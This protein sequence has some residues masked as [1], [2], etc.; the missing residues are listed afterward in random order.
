M[1]AAAR[2]E[3][4]AW[5]QRPV[6]S[7]QFLPLRGTPCRNADHELTRVGVSA[8]ELRGVHGSTDQTRSL[9]RTRLQ[10]EQLYECDGSFLLVRVLLPV[11][12]D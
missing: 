4:S 5:R 8:T 6:E 3:R 2:V 9:T 7:V 12:K 11:P 10:G 1:R